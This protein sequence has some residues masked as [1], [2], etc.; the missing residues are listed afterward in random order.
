MGI[1]FKQSQ[2]MENKIYPLQDYFEKKPLIPLFFLLFF[3]SLLILFAYLGN[4]VFPIADDHSF[5]M[6]LR[7]LSPWEYEKNILLTW[8]GRYIAYLGV[9]ILAEYINNIS[10]YHA[11]ASIHILSLFISIYI[12]VSVAS[13]DQGLPSKLLISLCL[14]TAFITGFP[15]PSQGLYWMTGAI[16][17]F[18]PFNL[19]FL[20]L[21]LLAY[22]AFE[23][24]K[25]NHFLSAITAFII[26]LIMGGNEI[27]C[28]SSVALLFCLSSYAQLIKHSKRKFFIAFFLFCLFLLVASFLAPGNFVRAG[29]IEAE[30]TREWRW[31]FLINCLGGAFEGFKWIFITPVFISLVFVAFVFKPRWEV[32]NIFFS[33]KKR[34]VFILLIGL[35][36]FFLDFLLV[37]I[38]SKRAPYA[39]INNAIFAGAF[40]YGLCAF[41]LLLPEIRRLIKKMQIKIGVSKGF[42]L[43]ACALILFTLG[44]KTVYSS[45]CNLGNGSFTEYR[46]IWEERLNLVEEAKK[47]GLEELVMPGLKS[48]PFPIVFRD[49]Q[50]KQDKHQWIGP[51]FAR[52][53]GFEKMIVTPHKGN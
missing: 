30:A 39:R 11:Y 14:T 36:L 49:I 24:E 46:S 51:L 18:V 34:L 40:I 50:E 26:F 53:H 21:A 6:S 45:I 35:G 38:S 7:E 22:L 32:E 17:Y 31:S 19:S 10:L 20:L 27:T 42:A 29:L 3:S 25:W 23:P 48:R 16:T 4:F 33:L 13:K 47:E 15:S 12:L 37:Y 9:W 5:A 8:S 1:L 28:F 43:I 52:Y 41:A 2:F 44:Q